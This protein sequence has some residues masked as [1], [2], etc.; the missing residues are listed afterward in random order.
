MAFDIGGFLGG[1]IGTVGAFGAAIYSLKKHQKNEE[2]SKNRKVYDL[3]ISVKQKL[4]EGQ[5]DIWVQDQDKINGLMK[6][7]INLNLELRRLIP[8]TIE[9]DHR[10]TS[11]IQKCRNDLESLG[12]EYQ[13][14]P[15][16]FENIEKYEELLT[17]LIT[18]ADSECDRIIDD[19]LA[20]YESKGT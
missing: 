1:I 6:S 15:K 8:D 7:A 12:K 9:T 3:C 19:I 11:I 10:L 13:L 14:L 17:E 5:N 16:T 2:P 4:N 18:R 20:V